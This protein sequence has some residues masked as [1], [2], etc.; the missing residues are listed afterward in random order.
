MMI[1]IAFIVVI[2]C[3]LLLLG[4]YVIATYNKLISLGE[5]VINGKAQIA[6]QIESR[7]DAVANLIEA[8]KQYA[9]FEAET[10]HEITSK[11]VSVSGTSSIEEMERGDA[12][13]NEVIGRILAISEAYPD[14]KANE[15]YKTTMDSVNN[16]ENKVRHSRMI[17]ND[18]VTRYNRLIKMFPSNIV[19]SFFQFKVKHYFEITEQK[20][21]MPRWE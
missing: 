11:R 13:A 15:I 14:L 6:A 16:Y 20:D 3:M 12:Q 4:I 10:L 18:T 1:V 19:A 9:A 7:W 21:T 2:I 8:T 5:R 17:Y